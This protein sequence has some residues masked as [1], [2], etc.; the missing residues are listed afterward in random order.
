[1]TGEVG[2]GSMCVGLRRARGRGNGVC[3]SCGEIGKECLSVHV[4]LSVCALSVYKCTQSQPDRKVCAIV[5]RS[6]ALSTLWCACVC[7]CS[8]LTCDKPVEKA[9]PPLSDNQRGQTEGA[10]SPPLNGA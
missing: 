2:V 8:M 9:G 1:M 6:Y 4:F 5:P 7:P 3:F 10:D